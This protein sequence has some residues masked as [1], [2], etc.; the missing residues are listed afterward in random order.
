MSGSVLS[1]SPSSG[2]VRILHHDE[3]VEVLSAHGVAIENF[4]IEDELLLFFLFH[5]RLHTLADLSEVIIAHSRF[6][7]DHGECPDRSF[8]VG[9]AG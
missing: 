4:V 2:H 9:R 7:F 1:R 5:Y 8:G 6:G 3:N